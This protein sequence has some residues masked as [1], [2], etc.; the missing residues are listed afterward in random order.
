ME[1]RRRL[2]RLEQSCKQTRRALGEL[3]T[4]AMRRLSDRELLLLR[5]GLKRRLEGEVPAPEEEQALA[6]FQERY[7][8]V[9]R[10]I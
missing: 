6:V 10:A 9:A 3:R 5:D 7:E 2:E 8:E 4:Q 1:L